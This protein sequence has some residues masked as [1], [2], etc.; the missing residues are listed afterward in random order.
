MEVPRSARL[1]GRAAAEESCPLADA[2]QT[3]TIVSDGGGIETDAPILDFDP[4][5]VFALHQF[6]PHLVALAVSAG[7][8]QRLLDDAIDGIFQDGNEPVE[9]D[10]AV[11]LDLLA[12]SE[13]AVRSRDGQPP[14]RCPIHP[15]SAAERR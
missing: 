14:P 1:D 10:F 8:G 12:R 11:E 3:E 5:H 7:I 15:G 6:H 9:G 13:A 4:K 2:L